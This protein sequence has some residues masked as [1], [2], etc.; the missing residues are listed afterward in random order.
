MHGSGRAVKNR[1]AL[2]EF[3]TSDIK[4]KWGGRGPKCKFKHSWVEL[5]I[6]SRVSTSGGVLK[7]SQL[8]IE[9][10]Q[11][12]YGHRPTYVDHMS[13]C[14]SISPRPSLFFAA[15]PLPCL[16][17]NAN[18][19]A[20][21]KKNKQTNKQTGVDLGKRLQSWSDG[22]VHRQ[23]ITPTT[24]RL[25]NYNSACLSRQAF[26]PPTM[27]IASLVVCGTRRGGSVEDWILLCNC[28]VLCSGSCALFTVAIGCFRHQWEICI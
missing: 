18:Q 23:L 11:I 19:R 27:V 21:T 12:D 24:I 6:A 22:I 9:D 16:I 28:K 5:S 17:V 25:W 8:L 26:S 13:T 14:I 7:P 3:I 1:E 20:K 15:L 2:G 4:W 10:R